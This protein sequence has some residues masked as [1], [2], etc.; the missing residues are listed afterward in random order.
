MYI[1]NC[2]FK[3]LFIVSKHYKKSCL[4]FLM[5]ILMFYSQVCNSQQV[6]AN[7]ITGV[8]SMS[9]NSPEGGSHIIVMPNNRFV[10]AY[11]GGMRKGTWQYKNDTY[12]FTYHTESKLTLYGR[13]NPT[14]NDSIS[15][16]MNVNGRNDLAIRFNDNS[17]FTPI[18]NEGANCFLYPYVHTLQLALVTLEAFI[19][20][21]RRYYEGE[22]GAL[23]KIARFDI[24]ASYNQYILIELPEEYTVEASFTAIFKDNTMQIDNSEVIK[25]RNAYENINAEDMQYFEQFTNTELLP[26][27]L[28]YGNEF[29]P[30]FENPLE[31]DLIPYTRINFRTI[32]SKGISIAQTSLFI[33]RCED[34]D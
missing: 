10:T 30:Y 15:I 27:V 29:F 19:P 9:G 13:N 17:Q 34:E 16:A 32:A 6:E 5:T 28:A 20:D 31:T 3:P 33:S 2:K 25:K 14:I 26:P 12:W 4:L 21:K 8:Y 23:S 22:I 1:I 7:E 18:F 24:N 11:F